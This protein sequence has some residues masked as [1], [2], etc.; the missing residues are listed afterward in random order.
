M[1]IAFIIVFR[2][3]KA[4]VAAT[5]AKAERVPAKKNPIREASFS[6]FPPTTTSLDLDS[7]SPSSLVDSA[8]AE[9]DCEEVPLGDADADGVGV[10]LTDAEGVG[11]DGIGVDGVNVRFKLRV[12]MYE[13]PKPVPGPLE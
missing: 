4:T 11:V 6:A 2:W 5:P 7:T 3:K 12:K 13:S 8:E 1:V 10:D 9:G